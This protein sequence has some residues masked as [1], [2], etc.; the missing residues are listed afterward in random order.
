MSLEN[1]NKKRKRSQYKLDHYENPTR[2]DATKTTPH[3]FLKCHLKHAHCID[4]LLRLHMLCMMHAALHAR[5]MSTMN[6]SG[7]CSRTSSVDSSLPQSI[8]HKTQESNTRDASLS[9]V[10]VQH[11]HSQYQH[12]QQQYSSMPVD[13]KNVVRDL[14]HVHIKNPFLIRLEECIYRYYDGIH[15]HLYQNKCQQLIF[16]LLQNADY[17]M[18]FVKT[19]PEIFL[20]VDDAFLAKHTMV[21]QQKK[22]YEERQRECRNLI[23]NVNI[24]GPQNN[25]K[26][27]LFCNRCH[28]TAVDWICL[29]MRGCDEPMTVFCVCLN[30]KCNHHWTMNR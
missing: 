23:Q 28:G 10:L 4:P 18:A 19:C 30:K 29:Q 2:D 5:Q 14:N 1:N 24:F 17:L 8:I 7:S 25:Q 27:I 12:S 21:E 9:P 22:N 11:Q 15:V 26:A 20:V 6:D 3:L 16:N 13:L